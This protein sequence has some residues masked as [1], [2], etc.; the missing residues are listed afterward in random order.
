MN[1]GFPKKVLLPGSVTPVD[2]RDSSRAD[3][4]IRAGNLYLSLQDAIA[5]ALENNLD[6]ELERF[7]IRMAATDTYRATGGGSLRG[8]PLTVDETPAGIG[9]PNGNPLLT[10]AATGTLT[11]SVVSAAVTDTQLIAEPQDN[12]GTTGT[13]PYANGP[14]I[15]QFDPVL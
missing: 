2:M 1:R 5:L 13:F 11:Q 14:N 15:P 9:G 4:L 6:L 10:A 3:Q 12:L 7:G 8:V